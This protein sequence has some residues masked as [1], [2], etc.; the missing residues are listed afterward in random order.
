MKV[1]FIASFI[2][3]IAFIGVIVKYFPNINVSNS[4]QQN[5]SKNFYDPAYDTAK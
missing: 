5:A 4:E 2:L 1:L 3:N